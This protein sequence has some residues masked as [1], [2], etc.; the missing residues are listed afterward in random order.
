MTPFEQGFIKAAMA[1]GL[2]HYHAIELLKQASGIGAYFA[3]GPASRSYELNS[4]NAAAIG[5]LIGGGSITGEALTEMALGRLGGRKSEDRS[6]TISENTDKLDSEGYG[7]NAHRYGKTY[8]GPSA[9]I[10]GV[11]GALSGAALG[12][13]L[14]TLGGGA[15]GYMGG[16]LQG[17]YDKFVTNHT[18]DDSKRRA[19]DFKSKHPY[20]TALPF[21]DVIGAAMSKGKKQK[22]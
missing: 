1:E 20:A 11:G 10:G 21:G 7:A 9:L 22:D 4:P 2:N 5:D 18:N 13:G 15:L 6:K 3:S 14:G 8:A 19:H 17:L 16:G 12:G